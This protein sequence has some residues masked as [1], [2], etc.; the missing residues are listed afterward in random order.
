M[1]TRVTCWSLCVWKK[2]T[3][4]PFRL[5][6]SVG[7]KRSSR[8]LVVKEGHCNHS[9]IGCR[10]LL[11]LLHG[12]AA[13]AAVDRGV[14]WNTNCCSKKTSNFFRNLQQIQTPPSGPH[15]GVSHLLEAEHLQRLSGGAHLCC[16]CP[17]AAPCS[18]AGRFLLSDRETAELPP[19]P[20]RRRHPAGDTNRRCGQN[21]E[22]DRCESDG[23]ILQEC[24]L[25]RS[26]WTKMAS[27]GDSTLK[28]VQV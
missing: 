4:S 17:P 28:L 5:K 9:L 20:R 14:W 1:K 26:I 22:P 25:Y 24:H 11:L 18:S 19:E 2:R 3:S 6:V 27:F 13:E 16:A 12:L 15:V 7:L 21:H 10:L 23:P 8:P